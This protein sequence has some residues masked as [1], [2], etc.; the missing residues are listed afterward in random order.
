MP[1]NGKTTLAAHFAKC[2]CSTHEESDILG[3]DFPEE[4]EGLRTV[5]DMDIAFATVQNMEALEE[6]YNHAVTMKPKA[7]IMDGL[8]AAWKM[9]FTS[10]CPNLTMPSDNG[11]TWNKLATDLTSRLLVRFKSIPSVEVFLAVSTV[12]PDK[13]EATGDEKRLQT[14]L[15]GQLKGNIYGLFSYCFN[16]KVTEAQG[17]QV[18]ILETQPDPKVVAKMRV[19]LSMKVPKNIFYDLSDPTKGIEYLVKTLGLV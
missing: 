5:S 3:I 2:L 16:I 13:D 6:L 8:P 7:I 14:V 15:P 17:K 19:P 18:R 1:G 12:W 11:Q 4:D 10:R 9:F